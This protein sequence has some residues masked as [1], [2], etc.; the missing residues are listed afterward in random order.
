MKTK[1]IPVAIGIICFGLIVLVFSCQNTNQ[2][3][4]NRYY[5]SGSA[6]YQLHCQN[7][8]GAKGEGLQALI[9]PLTDYIYLKNNKNTLACFIKT[10]LKGRINIVNKT[11]EGEMPPNDLAP[12]EIAQVLTYVTNSF[13]NRSGTVTTE[14]VNAD[15]AKCY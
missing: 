12:L 11:Y 8:H 9:P 6:V 2:V 7:C 15:L 13:G 1:L 4:F 3:E 14:R 10:G 5:S